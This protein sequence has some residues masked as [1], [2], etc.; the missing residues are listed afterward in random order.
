MIA[1]IAS[2]HN[3]VIET[4]YTVAHAHNKARYL[5]EE[6]SQVV[7]TEI[8]DHNCL[9]GNF[10]WYVCSLVLRLHIYSLPSGN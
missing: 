6:A 7:L 10:T 9:I 1:D 4:F 8:D 3:G 5:P 2:A